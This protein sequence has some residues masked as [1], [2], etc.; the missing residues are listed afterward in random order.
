MMGRIIDRLRGTGDTPGPAPKTI[1]AA[2]MPM[3]GPGVRAVNRARMQ[4]T[5]E[6][7]QNDA[8]YYFD[9]NG[10][11]RSALTWIANAVSQADLHA[12]AI[13][14]DTGKPTGPSEDQ[15]AQTIAAMAFGG[16]AQR[17]GIL[18]TLAICWQCV[19]EAWIIIRP[20]PAGKGD[21]W[22][23]L[24]GDKVRAKGESWQ[25][26]DPM[27]GL[28]LTLGGTDRLLRV[29]SPH[30]HDQSKA[31]SA[32]RP[33]LPILREIE[34]ATQNIA[35]RLDSRI[36]MNGL[37]ALAEELDFPKGDFQTG[38]EAF[39]DQLLTNA[40]Y[41]L[42]NPGQAS[43]QVPMAFS[44]P[45][46]LI[47][48]GGAFAHYDI[49]TQFDGAVVELRQDGRTMLAGSLD[50]PK[51]V[52][53]G[54]QGEGN[55]WSDWKVEE[56]TYKIYIEPLLKALGNAVDEHW[57][58][59][60][61]IAD[62]MA[63]DQAEF[64][65]IGWDTTAI[66]ARPDASE[67]LES[68]YD[69]ILIS[70]EYMLAEHGVPEDAMPSQ[71][72]RTRRLLEKLVSVAPTLM[73]DPAVA[74][75]LDIGIEIAPVAAGVDA[76][77]SSGGELEAPTP[78]PAPVRGL[79]SQRTS[80]DAPQDLPSGLAAAAELIVYDALSRAGGRLLTNQNRGQFKATPR[81]ELYRAIN[82]DGVD[83]SALLEGSFVFV[84]RVAETFGVQPR[85]LLSTLRCYTEDLLAMP[86]REHRPD[87]L[88]ARL[89]RMMDWQ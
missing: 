88:T 68:L 73:A 81:H 22:L 45:G 28:T 86:Q 58:R 51:Q 18:K 89:E 32:V 16:F 47:A 83:R 19:G 75:A 59:P 6:T 87:R 54:S 4:S 21:T 33:A 37:M 57:F 70:D 65:E 72:E 25:F 38:S 5:T 40:E 44:A 49:S 14:P 76:N 56:D 31:D 35:A 36:A 30:P 77:V 69:K 8:W 63:P 61:L 67:T 26:T 11:L 80:A 43:S 10:E 84:D 74:A 85:A 3:S 66:V 1:L 46:E 20:G 62:G 15:R 52:A 53:E 2:A 60:A 42:Q 27:T 71:E 41:G 48:N 39:M 12:T 82:L 24:A 9:V 29:W 23:A 13:D 7:W 34:K 55:H 78:E 79:P 64:Q 50:M 17:A